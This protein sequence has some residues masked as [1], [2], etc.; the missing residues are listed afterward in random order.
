MSS[1]TQVF[2][3]RDLRRALARL[4]GDLEDASEEAVAETAEQVKDDMQTFVPV[5]SGRL[6]D[7]I[8]VEI[9][10]GGKGARVGPGD[11]VEYSEF[12]EFGTSEM[13]A[14]PYATPAA[15]AARRTLPAQVAGSVRRRVS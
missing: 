1:R 6:R 9:T 8:T 15:E 10:A 3:M 12:V 4:A 5:D 2:G 13:E 7:A 11:E 14:Q